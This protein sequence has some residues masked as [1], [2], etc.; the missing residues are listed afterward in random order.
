MDGCAGPCPL[1]KGCG[2]QVLVYG[3]CGNARRF[4]LDL[5]LESK[6][7]SESQLIYR[8]MPRRLKSSRHRIEARGIR[9]AYH[10]HLMIWWRQPRKSARSA[11]PPAIE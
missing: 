8:F 6:P 5:A 1:L 9:L 10:Y 2:S 7:S 11:R 3:E 4:P